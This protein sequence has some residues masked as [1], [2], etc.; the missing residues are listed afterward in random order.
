MCGVAGIIADFIAGAF[1]V[2]AGDVVEGMTGGS[3]VEWRGVKGKHVCDVAGMFA[4]L[5]AGIVAG[6]LP[7]LLPILLPT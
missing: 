7:I 3:D 1:A 2:F 5:I 4:D 6:I